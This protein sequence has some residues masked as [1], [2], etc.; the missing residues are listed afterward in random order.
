MRVWNLIPFV[1]STEE[2]ALV[3][4]GFFRRS[5]ENKGKTN[6][7]QLKFML[8]AAAAFGIA[9]AQ[10]ETPQ[11]VNQ[12][13][14]SEDFESF[15]T[16]STF[17]DL[18]KDGFSY[19]GD[20][21]A[22][23]ESAIVEGGATTAG[24]ALQVNTGTNPILRKLDSVY[25]TAVNLAAA[26][27]KKLYIDTMVQF[28]VTPYGDEVEASK[29]ENGAFNDK[30]MIYLKECVGSV[31]E[32]GATT[33]FVN[34]LMVKAAKYK[35]ADFITT[36]VPT[37]E[38]CDVEISNA[39]VVAGTWYN[40]RVTSYVDN[41]ITLF[42][43]K[44]DDTELASSEP[45]YTDDAK[46]IFPALTGNSDTTVDYVGFAGEGKVD[47]IVITKDVEQETVVNFTFTITLAEGV[48]SVAY[49]IG[50]EAPVTIY[51]NTEVSGIT[52]DSTVVVTAV[53]KDWYKIA[54]GT[55]TYTATKNE[56]IEVTA[57]ST[58]TAD[59][60]NITVPA[61][62]APADLGIKPGSAFYD[63][64]ASKALAAEL[65]KALTWAMSKGGAMT[66]SAAAGVVNGLA[67]DGDEETDEEK[68]YLLDCTKAELSGENGE[69]AKFKFAGFDPAT[70]TFKVGTEKQVGDKAAYGNGYVE[71]RGSATVGG[72]YDEA[73]DK[74][75]HSFFK[76]FLVPFQP[77]AVDAE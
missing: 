2:S 74:S 58:A 10:A 36:L 8:A 56:T 18:E 14:D 55:G 47:D 25:C 76:A 68:A 38:E 6:M 12:P 37:F 57:E 62:T 39:E 28:T 13:V 45:L 44:L 9:T 33:N 11:I 27:F 60:N 66:A 34:K 22:D 63:D 23:N 49:T 54:S 50:N 1:L 21:P 16:A 20:V 43:I 51:E 77:A 32:D 46:K 42:T 71:V 26:K 48:S 24:Y 7:K 52:K 31:S 53:P 3:R 75:K 72:A 67:F 65:S 41:G 35:N 70:G 5:R 17:A 40:L 19:D 73:A 59:G 61:T 64:K 4:G 29:D 15:T 69:I 30:L